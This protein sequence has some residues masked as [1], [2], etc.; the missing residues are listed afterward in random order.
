MNVVTKEGS[1][2]IN[3]RF[4]VF[5]EET[6]LDK[7]SI[8]E[9]G[10]LKLLEG[11]WCSYIEPTSRN[12]FKVNGNADFKPESRPRGAGL[13]TTC[14]P[15]PG[16]T[17][18]QIGGKF[19]FVCEE[20]LDAIRFDLVPGGV[21][22]RGGAVEQFCG[23]VKYE[24][25]VKAV[26][27]KANPN[28]WQSDTGF[29]EVTNQN[30]LRNNKMESY[31]RIK[32]YPEIHVENGMYLWLNKILNHPATEKSIRTDRGIYPLFDQQDVA[33]PDA[34]PPP[35]NADPTEAPKYQDETVYWCE[36]NA[37]TQEGQAKSLIAYTQSAY[38]KL[39]GT[40]PKIVEV[41]PSKELRPGAGLNGPFYVP[42][43][44]ISRSGVIPHGSTVTATGK[45][46]Y[47]NG[48]PTF[49]ALPQGQTTLKNPYE[50]T[51]HLAIHPTM[52]AKNLDN[53]FLDKIWDPTLKKEGKEG[54]FIK[55][56]WIDNVHHSMDP[57]ENRIYILPVLGH[58]LYP[59]S[60]RPDLFLRDATF[61]QKIADH[62]MISLDTQD[63]SREGVPSG[64]IVNIPF[65]TRFVNTTEMRFNM[66]LETVE[67]N[68][69]LILQLQYEQIVF[70]EFG[71]GDGGGKTVWPHIQVSTLRRV[72]DLKEDYP[73]RQWALDH[74]RY[75]APE[76][77]K[78]D[79]L[80]TCDKVTCRNKVMCRK[81]CRC[82]K[83]PIADMD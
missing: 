5:N 79:A 20:Y 1:P 9:Y 32:H 82:P 14:M 78:V 26:P 28:D 8:A 48:K 62:V 10:L 59:Y 56:S 19:R 2:S 47:Q 60:V 77:K 81:G 30:S 67:E 63:S 69:E 51:E 4:K 46:R 70:F 31:D 55:P 23:A 58:Q 52:G 35:T 22:N 68:G 49:V 83:P 72:Q 42:D 64:G 44:W 11:V 65:V 61:N 54:G 16:T 41:R 17:S 57:Q 6:D 13:H 50:D 76:H 24:Q 29:M 38:N 25:I 43:Y 15:S 45:G 33:N 37:S 71:H 34:P 3:T 18:D 80:K 53:F 27:T 39:G 75:K 12:I 7:E 66:W 74:F 73:T 40:K 36:N 21:R